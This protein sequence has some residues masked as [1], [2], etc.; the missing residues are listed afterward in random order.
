MGASKESPPASAR[1]WIKQS[2]TA[3]P[4]FILSTHPQ[5]KGVLLV[6]KY[7]CAGQLITFDFHGP[8]EAFIDYVVK[9]LKTP[10]DYTVSCNF[11][12]DAVQATKE[13]IAEYVTFLSYTGRR[14]HSHYCP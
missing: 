2:P 14:D 5:L 9:C 12:F 4:A 6:G 8:I 1:V 10:T 3:P 7:M 13:T 11:G